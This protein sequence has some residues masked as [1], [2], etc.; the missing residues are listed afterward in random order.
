[1]A[2]PSYGPLGITRWLIQ[3]HNS[4]GVLHTKRMLTHANNR[5]TSRNLVVP[6]MH[7]LEVALVVSH[8][9]ENRQISA[10]RKGKSSVQKEKRKN[11]KSNV[12]FPHEKKEAG[13]RTEAEKKL[14]SIEKKTK[15]VQ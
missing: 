10:I 15:N 11:E 9:Q 4:H 1:M 7:L 5:G 6:S 2:L 14:E 3:V 12:I 13:R 8:C